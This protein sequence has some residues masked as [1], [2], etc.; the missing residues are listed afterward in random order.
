MI[1]VAGVASDVFRQTHGHGLEGIEWESHVGSMLDRC[2]SRCNGMFLCI[3]SWYRRTP[4]YSV[5][6]DDARTD[7]GRGII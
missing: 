2:F 1:G 7:G 5:F 3:I 4:L 6:L